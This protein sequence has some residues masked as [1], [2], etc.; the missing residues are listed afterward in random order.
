MKKCMYTSKTK[1]AYRG[2][3]KGKM[4]MIWTKDIA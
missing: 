2:K 1:F 3:K 4:K